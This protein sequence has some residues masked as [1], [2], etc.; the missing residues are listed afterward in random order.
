MKSERG[1]TLASLVIYVIITVMGVAILATIMAYF[2]KDVR[3]LSR[4]NIE[5]AELDKFYSYFL[6]DVKNTNND[7]SEITEGNA[8]ITFTSGNTYTFRDETIFFNDNIKLAENIESCTFTEGEEN[9]KKTITTSI[10]INENTYSRKFV[11]SNQRTNVALINEDDYTK[12]D[13]VTKTEYVSDGKTAQ[14]PGGFVVSGIVSEQSIDNG[15]VIYYQGDS[16]PI[17]WTDE[18][19]REEYDQFVWIPII[20][21]NGNANPNTMFICQA[22]TDS[23]GDCDI[24]L[25]NSGNPICSNHSSLENSDKMAGRFYGIGTGTNMGFNRNIS[26]TLQT[27]ENSAQTREPD[28]IEGITLDLEDIQEE[29]NNMVKSVIENKGFWIGRYESS[30]LDGDVRVVAGATVN[31]G[32]NNVMWQTM[33]ENQK[34][35]ADDKNCYGGM[36][37]GAAYDQIMLFVDGKNIFNDPNEGPYQ[38]DVLGQV[39]H[40]V[41]QAY[42]TG[43]IDYPTQTS[44]GNYTNSYK[45]M[46]CNIYDLEGNVRDMTTEVYSTNRF[47]CRGGNY[48]SSNWYACYRSALAVTRSAATIGSRMVLFVK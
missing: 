34:T 27:Y 7:I 15:L 1:I 46:V 13:K 9:G 48:N 5:I 8:S 10:T 42:P 6:Q 20:D 43:N 29:Y 2:S 45:D 14:I 47:M 25:D 26:P 37:T 35:Y 4:D 16:E 39:T 40:N 31:D 24:T 11:L 44:V 36:M 12:P 21:A 38:I 19:L 32:I 23:N 41:A 30:G 22:K 28:V 3:D 17:D 33:Y 18:N